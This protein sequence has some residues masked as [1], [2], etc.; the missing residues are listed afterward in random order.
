M[1]KE[2]LFALWIIV[3]IARAVSTLTGAQV[4]AKSFVEVLVW[5]CKTGKISYMICYR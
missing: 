2:N 5:V 3:G 4:Y 1:F